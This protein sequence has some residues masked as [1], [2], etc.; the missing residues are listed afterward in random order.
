MPRVVSLVRPSLLPLLVTPL[1]AAALILTSIG[2]GEAD[3]GGIS[4]SGTIE[5]VDVTVS[6]KVSGEVIRR[7]VD[8]GSRV[9]KGD[10]IAVIRNLVA[11]IELQQ[12]EAGAAAAKADYDLVVRGPR[13]EDIEQ[14]KASLE[15]ADA[16]HKRAQQLYTDKLISDRELETARTRYVLAHEAL[17][18]LQRGA[19]KEEKDRAKSRYEQAVAQVA[20]IRK[21]LKDAHV[22]SPADGVV[23][24]RAVEEGELVPAG[25]PIV[26]VSI[27]DRVRLIIYVPETQLGRLKIG[28][29]V[30]VSIDSF[31]DRTFPGRIIYISPTAEFTPKNV[32]TQ[33][34]RVKLMFAV[35]VEVDNPGGELKPGLP[36]DA[37]IPDE[38]QA[39]ASSQ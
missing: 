31:A 4:A 27:L 2:C 11:D 23:T 35:K 6:A 25:G 36:A 7:L 28:Q 39:A 22:L 8:E 38:A 37:F 12:A 21:R 18:K 3:R 19:L 24:L 17:Q 30:D 13:S 26:R 10:T 5:V 34:E 14:A 16:D 33:E 15:S 29:R 1:L 20:L 9:K 32:Q